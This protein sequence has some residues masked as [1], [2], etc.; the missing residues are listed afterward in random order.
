MCDDDK[1]GP[2]SRWRLIPDRQYV[3]EEG[4][5]PNSE[6]AD[7]DKEY[8]DAMNWMTTRHPPNEPRET[9]PI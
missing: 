5:V 4:E 1:P 9:L 3:L 7:W 8:W 2:G 6:R